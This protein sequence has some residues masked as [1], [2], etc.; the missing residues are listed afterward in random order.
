MATVKSL[1][2]L[3]FGLLLGGLLLTLTLFVLDI[4]VVDAHSLLDLGAKGRLVGG[5][6]GVSLRPNID[7]VLRYLQV[8]QLAVVHLEKHAGDL[9][10]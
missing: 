6:V 2:L 4:F 5:A 9:A 1:S 10:S 7:R 3:I 8:D